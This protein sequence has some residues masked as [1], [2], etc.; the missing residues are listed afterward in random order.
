MNAGQI[1]N[2]AC[3]N[4]FIALKR[5]RKSETR[6]S[7]VTILHRWRRIPQQHFLLEAA[8]VSSSWCP[9][10][11]FICYGCCVENRRIGKTFWYTASREGCER[12]Q[13]RSRDD[14]FAHRKIVSPPIIWSR[15]LARSERPLCANGSHA[16]VPVTLLQI[17]A[18]TEVKAGGEEYLDENRSR[19]SFVPR[20]RREEV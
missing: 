10:H 15:R 5:R 6:V 13:K 14:D 11:A 8:Y 16:V 1:Y 17:S 9:A 4:S 19:A 3:I 20:K 7:N 18:Q 2:H 12:R